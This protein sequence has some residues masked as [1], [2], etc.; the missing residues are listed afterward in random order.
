M[1]S[2]VAG[3]SGFLWAA[4]SAALRAVVVAS[5]WFRPSWALALP[6]R[7]PRCCGFVPRLEV[8]MSVSFSPFVPVAS[9]VLLRGVPAASVVPVPGRLG[10]S[11]GVVAG[12]AWVSGPLSGLVEVPRVGASGV[13]VWFAG[14]S[15]PL[16]CLVAALSA[17]DLALLV[18]SVES[19]CASGSVV[20]P[21]VGCGSGRPA[22]GFLCGLSASGPVAASPG[23][24]CRL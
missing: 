5:F 24:G 16:V 15:A 3:W 18:A 1:A 2:W 9:S 11:G 7:F 17:A 22:P 23:G 6:G 12:A 20:F 21:V 8:S 13:A 14:S 19:A 4:K 10:S